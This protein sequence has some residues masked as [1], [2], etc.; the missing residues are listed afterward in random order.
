MLDW[1]MC[2]KCLGD[3]FFVEVGHEGERVFK[4]YLCPE[5]KNYTRNFRVPQT[6]KEVVEDALAQEAL[7][8]KVDV[9]VDDSEPWR[10]TKE[11]GKIKQLKL[12]DDD[13]P[14]IFY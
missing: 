2:A 14:R 5:C 4:L 6:E 11:W 7:S 8:A 9:V 1:T 13:K 12:W 10:E 3:A